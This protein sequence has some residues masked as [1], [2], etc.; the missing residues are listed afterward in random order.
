MEAGREVWVVLDPSGTYLK[1]DGYSPPEVWGATVA[2]A[3]R[4]VFWVNNGFRF[5]VRP[6]RVFATK[7]RAIEFA[8]RLGLDAKF[9]G[10]EEIQR[11]IAELQAALASLEAADDVVVG[12]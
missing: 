9:A 10:R 2:D 7:E 12:Q 11:K 3:A 1:A 4:D 5:I 8:C 6:N